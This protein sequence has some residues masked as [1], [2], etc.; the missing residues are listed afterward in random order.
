MVKPRKLTTVGQLPNYFSDETILRAEQDVWN[1]KTANRCSLNP[2][3]LILAEEFQAIEG[4]FA[5]TLTSI[6][7]GTEDLLSPD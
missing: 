2:Q 4:K 1:N 5:S 7:A 3:M 6:S